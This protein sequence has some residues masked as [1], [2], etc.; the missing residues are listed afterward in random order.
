MGEMVG[1]KTS[2]RETN[3]SDSSASKP[4]ALR[5]KKLHDLQG[6]GAR[7]GAHQRSICV[8]PADA[9]QPERV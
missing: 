8:H 6:C 9:N 2:S 4:K 5:K 7:A 3:K 1:E